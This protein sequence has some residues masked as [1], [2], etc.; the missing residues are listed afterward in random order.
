M[1][2]IP[3]DPADQ[4]VTGLVITN[5]LFRPVGPKGTH[6][7]QAMDSFQQAGLAGGIGADNE[8]KSAAE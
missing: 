6:A 5:R 3:S 1:P 4:P 7:S 2:R 8:I